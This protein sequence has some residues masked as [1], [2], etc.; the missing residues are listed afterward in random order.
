VTRACVV[1]LQTR[2]DFDTRLERDAFLSW[3]V[4]VLSALLAS[5]D[6]YVRQELTLFEAALKWAQ[7]NA[8]GV[9]VCVCVCMCVCVCGC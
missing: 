6:L 9:C 7:H 8:K 4:E 5:D 2:I 1:A 3:P